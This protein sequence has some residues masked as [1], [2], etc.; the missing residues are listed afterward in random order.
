MPT[1]TSVPV[2]NNAKLSAT[3]TPKLA[4]CRSQSSNAATP[5]PMRPMTPSGPIG[6]RS[7]GDRNASAVMAAIAAAVTQAI[8]TTA[9]MD[10]NMNSSPAGADLDRRA[11]PRLI[12]HPLDGWSHRA[13]KQIR[14]HSHEYRHRHNRD[15][16]RPLPR[17]QIRECRILFAY[18]AVV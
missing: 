5:A 6:M 17:F 9:L 18:R 3:T 2:T 15:D 12:D 4:A 10:A 1:T 13:Q 11:A 14:Q 7:P 16:Q 8:G